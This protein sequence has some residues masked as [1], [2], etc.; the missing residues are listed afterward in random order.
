MDKEATTRIKIY[1]VSSHKQQF[2]C[3]AGDILSAA[4]RFLCMRLGALLYERTHHKSTHEHLLPAV[5]ANQEHG[6]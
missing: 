1:R 6:W 2:C 3:A 5:F 4:T